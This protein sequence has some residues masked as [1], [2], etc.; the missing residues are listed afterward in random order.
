ME[1]VSRLSSGSDLFEVLITNT[2]KLPGV[3]VDRKEFL[4]KS[5]SK[6]VTAKQ[7]ADILEKGPVQTNISKK[8][9]RRVA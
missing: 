9:I 6:H 7:L 3:K 1:E 2:V 8:L 4:A 5:F